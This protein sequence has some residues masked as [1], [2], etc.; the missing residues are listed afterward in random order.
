MHE[1]KGM[2]DPTKTSSTH[3]RPRICFKVYMFFGIHTPKAWIQVHMFINPIAVSFWPLHTIFYHSDHESNERTNPTKTSST[4]S[5]TQTEL[6][7]L[8]VFPNTYS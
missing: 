3:P 8:Y 2:R 7:S 6:Q 5:K 4:P 1:S